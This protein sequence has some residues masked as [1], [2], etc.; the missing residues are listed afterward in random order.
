M[1]GGKQTKKEKPL[2]LTYREL[3]DN[4][5]RK[6]ANDLLHESYPLADPS[7]DDYDVTTKSV[8]DDVEELTKRLF[9]YYDSKR[10]DRDAATWEQVRQKAGA[11]DL[12]GATAILDR[13]V[14]TSADGSG[15]IPAARPAMAAIYASWGKAL[16]GQSKWSEASAAYAKAAGLDPTGAGANDA[17]A[18]HHYTLGKALE[19]QGKD[20][21]AEFRRATALRPDYAPAKAAEAETEPSSPRPLWMLYA[22]GLAGAVALLMFGIAMMRRR[23]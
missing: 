7:L 23:A 1:A 15:G 21:G 14:A 2:W 18:A 11:S 12:A 5:L 6:A 19:A 13:M 16:E 10:A 22:A 8:H 3:A 9:D 20:G 17:L 4:E